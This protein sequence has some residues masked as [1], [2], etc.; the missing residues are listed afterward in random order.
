[1][2][3]QITIVGRLGKDPEI[4]KLNN[5]ATVAR[6]SAAVDKGYKNK[7]GT[8]P[9]AEWFNIDAYQAKDTGIVT[10]LIQ[11][12]LKK[13]QLVF[14]AG[15][16]TIEKYTKDGVEQRV[17]KIKLGPQSTLKMLGGTAKPGESGGSAPALTGGAAP[18]DDDIPW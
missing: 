15:E 11:P 14:I 18:G 17:F 3:A 8:K 2:Y 4:K 7:D 16:P 10:N 12:Y 1:M 9:D 13:G 6:F 5:G